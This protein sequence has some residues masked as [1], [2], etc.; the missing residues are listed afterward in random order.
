MSPARP[1]ASRGYIMAKTVAA[2][3]EKVN[4]PW[5]LL[6]AVRVWSG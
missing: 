6:V 3:I 5:R 1:K 4:V 2:Q